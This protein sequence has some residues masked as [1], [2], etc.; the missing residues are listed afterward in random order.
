MSLTN[1][2]FIAQKYNVTF[3]DKQMTALYLLN[4]EYTKEL[5]YGGAKGGGKSVLLCRYMWMCDPYI[6]LSS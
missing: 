2:D 3:T 4:L 6:L 5:L 1:F